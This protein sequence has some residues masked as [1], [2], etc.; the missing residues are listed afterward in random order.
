MLELMIRQGTDD[1]DDAVE[2]NLPK[3]LILLVK[4]HKQGFKYH[5][6]EFNQFFSLHKIEGLGALK[7]EL[8][9]CQSLE[10]DFCE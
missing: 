6:Q 3:V 4:N 2:D 10:I 8:M 7:T 5:V 9:K 1:E